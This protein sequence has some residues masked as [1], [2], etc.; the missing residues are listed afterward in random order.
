MYFGD[1][2]S[3]SSRFRSMLRVFGTTLQLLADIDSYAEVYYTRKLV[4]PGDFAVSI[5]LDGTGAE[6]LEAGN[7]I[8]VGNGYSRLGIIEEIEKKRLSRGTKWLVVRGHE[9][10]ALFGR[11]IVL[12]ADGFE[13]MEMTAPAESVMKALVATQCGLG[14]VEKRR[15]P[16]LIVVDDEGRGLNY[17]ISSRLS[18]LLTELCRC[19]RSSGLGFKLDFDDTGLAL[20]FDVIAG[21]DR[22]AEQSVNPR[23]LIAEGYDTMKSAEIKTRSSGFNNTIYV[24]GK[25]SLENW[26]MAIVWNDLEPEG[27]NRFER[28][29]DAP[30]LQKELDLH[31]YGLGKLASYPE[32]FFL[33]AEVQ[34]EAPVMP[35]EDYFL[36]DVCS[37]EAYGQ[38]YKVPLESIEERW[39]Q[40]GPGIRLGFGR[41]ALGSHSTAMRETE[42]LWEMLR[43]G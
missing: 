42:S 2:P 29:L 13:R 18:N 21:M 23:A 40:D 39:T 5:P 9:A 28:G 6:S 33:E 41:P 32:E 43:S 7:F 16:G 36:G 19:A 35:D 15:I 14:T 34:D 12:P 3:M 31:T 24:E 25:K 8:L 26:P 38:W 4:E 1:T 10:K 30:L 22:S 11:R 27:F 17:T 37:V 20:V